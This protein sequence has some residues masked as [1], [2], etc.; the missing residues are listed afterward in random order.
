MDDLPPLLFEA[1]D[2]IAVLTLN[3]PAE[4][5]ALTPGLLAALEEAWHRVEEDRAIRVAII[6]GAG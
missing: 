1:E 6:T 4:G 5:N 2:G 3:R